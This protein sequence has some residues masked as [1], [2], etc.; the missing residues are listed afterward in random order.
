VSTIFVIDSSPA[1]RR[2][3]E[4]ISKPEG[5]DVVGFQDGA[6]AL[7]AAGRMS[8]KLIIAEYHL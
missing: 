8:P 2:L 4:Q 1:V 7:K 5:C 6:A 3:V